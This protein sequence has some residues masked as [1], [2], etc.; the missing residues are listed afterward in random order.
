MSEMADNVDRDKELEVKSVFWIKV[1]KY[2]NETGCGG[3]RCVKS[4]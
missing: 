3:S 1:S 2:Y 4:D